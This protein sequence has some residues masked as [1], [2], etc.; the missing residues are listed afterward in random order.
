MKTSLI[1]IAVVVGA[2]VLLTIVIVLAY[3]IILKS[4]FKSFRQM[5]KNIFDDD[6]DWMV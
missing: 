6:N 1:I 5:T 4:A 3:V 2:I